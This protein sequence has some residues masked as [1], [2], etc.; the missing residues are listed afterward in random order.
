MILCLRLKR[1]SRESILFCEWGGI[2]YDILELSLEF[3]ICLFNHV[4]KSTNV[5]THN[6]AN[7]HCELGEHRIWRN[8]L[9]P[10]C[11]P[12]LINEALAIF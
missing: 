4:S 6:I 12:Y 11:N 8:S 5:L 10:L 3:D 2:L 9:P 7:I 1:S